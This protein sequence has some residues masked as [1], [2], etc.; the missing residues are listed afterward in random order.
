MAGLIGYL[1]ARYIFVDWFYLLFLANGFA[2]RR[3][4]S[5]LAAALF[6][7]VGLYGT[8][9]GF[10]LIWIHVSQST[11]RFAVPLILLSVSY[12]L[13]GGRALAAAIKLQAEPLLTEIN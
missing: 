7:F 10:Y 3:Y 9:L 12:V 5:R 1:L 2:L 6:I 11:L 8:G 13:V 4:K